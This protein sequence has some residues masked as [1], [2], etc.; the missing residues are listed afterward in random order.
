MVGP[1]DGGSSSTCWRREWI[2]DEDGRDNEDEGRGSKSTVVKRMLISKVRR[3][4]LLVAVVQ[5]LLS[6]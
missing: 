2:D 1:S 6:K 4:I 5:W 3:V